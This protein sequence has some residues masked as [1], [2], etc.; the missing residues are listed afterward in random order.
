MNWSDLQPPVRVAIL[1]GV[2]LV[3]LIVV[4][5][6]F[7]SPTLARQDTAERDL[8]T[9][10]QQLE[11]LERQIESVPPASDTERAAWQSSRDEMMSRLGPESELPLLLESL[12]RLADSQGVEIFITSGPP[13]AVGS[14]PSGRRGFAEGPS[15]ADQVLGTVPGASY[16]PLNI[17]VYGDY[18]AS[19]RFISQVGRLGWATALTGI[20]MARDFPEVT[21]DVGLNVFFRPSGD[22][23]DFGAARGGGVAGARGGSL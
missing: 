17:R 16:V 4:W 13:T 2:A 6:L 15:Q 11:Q 20:V 3:V 22:G 7:V 8:T 18:E 19:S 12:A 21:S 23:S 14:E 10:E 9:A 1:A 5:S